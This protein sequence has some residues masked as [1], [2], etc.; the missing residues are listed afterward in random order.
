MLVSMAKIRKFRGLLLA[1][2]SF[3]F[4][5]THIYAQSYYV[6]QENTFYGGPVVGANFCQV[7]GD[8]Y[9]GYYKTGLNVGGIVYTRFGQRFAGSLEILYSQKGSRGH[10]AQLANLTKEIEIRQYG[11]SLDYAEIPIMIHVMDKRKSHI[12]VGLSYSQLVSSK[13]SLTTNNPK[14][15][16][17]VNISGYPFRRADV[18]LLVGFNL[19]LVK[20]LFFNVRYQ[21]SLAPIRTDVNYDFSRAKQ[22]NNLY[23]VRLVYLFGQKY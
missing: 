3:L 11:I 12:G 8:D 15:D 10:K 20:G 23:V 13:E 18:N 4:T 22:F 19:R 2:V 9:A 1:L 5:A 14:Y 16:D 7:D 21:Y 17:T 6:E